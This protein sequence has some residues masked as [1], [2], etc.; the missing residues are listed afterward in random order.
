MLGHIV[1][2]H[3]R[4]VN[5][6][7]EL[8]AGLA[9]SNALGSRGQQREDLDILHAVDIAVKDIERGRILTHP[10]LDLDGVLKLLTQASHVGTT[11]NEDDAL[12]VLIGHAG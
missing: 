1:T 10:H 5:K 8:D 4:S 3:D 12:D 6:S 7:V 9:L 2:F 11:A